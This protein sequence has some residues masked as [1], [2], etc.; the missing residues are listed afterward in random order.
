MAIAAVL[1]AVAALLWIKTYRAPPGPVQIAAPPG[2]V[3]IVAQPA[4]PPAPAQVSL[5]PAKLTPVEPAPPPPSPDVIAWSLVDG[6]TDDD[7][8]KRFV[9]EYPDS[10]FRKAAET[11]IASLAAEAE[12]VAAANRKAMTRSLQIELKRV[13][14]YQGDVT[15]QFDDATKA[16]W[17]SFASLASVAMPDDVSA[18]ALKAVRGVGKRV[19]PLVCPSGQHGDGDLC[20]ANAPPPASAASATE[21]SRPVPAAK[22][23][24]APA[25]P[26]PKCFNFG[27][28]QYCE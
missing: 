14:C 19:C 21:P 23:R 12:R 26:H 27:G 24:P 6:T 8:L 15:G 25:K 13:G 10:R 28:N 2:P 16:A 17:H 11:Q 20:V 3:P 1:V 5:P 18:D 7:S 9:A 4:A 22:P